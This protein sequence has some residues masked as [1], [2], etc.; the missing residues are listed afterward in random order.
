MRKLLF[1]S[2]LGRKRWHL[3]GGLNASG[4]QVTAAC[5]GA[6]VWQ[7][8][9][10]QQADLIVLDASA[11]SVQLNPWLLIAE[12]SEL[13]HLRLIVLTRAGRNQ[14]RV[15]AFQAGVRYCLSMPVS[16]AE[17]CA[18]LLTVGREDHNGPDGKVK[19]VDY[20]DLALQIDFANRQIRRKGKT[21]PLTG[22]EHSLL[23]RLI[24]NA[25]RV[26]PSTELCQS[27]WGRGAWPAK[28]MLLKTYILQLRRK[29][30]HDY[31]HPRYLV[32]HRGLGYAFMPQTRG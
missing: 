3:I 20:A 22:R 9:M 17:L 1:A 6:Q 18:L 8:L 19:L 24:G 28:R 25:G 27:T 10:R 12:L 13:D 14:D 2:A 5:T 4:F 23:Q 30:E 16:S 32:S 7:A 26:S 15:R 11:S 31:R 21:F 29:I